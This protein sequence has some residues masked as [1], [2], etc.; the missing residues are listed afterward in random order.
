MDLENEKKTLV[1]E[2][3]TTTLDDGEKQAK[4]GDLWVIPKP[5]V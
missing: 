5:S 2:S 1:E 4:M 3:T